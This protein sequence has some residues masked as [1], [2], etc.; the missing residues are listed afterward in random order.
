[1]IIREARIE[2]VPAITRI[3]NDAI[4]N[5]T[6]VYFYEPVSEQS[7]REWLPGKFAAGWRVLDLMF[8]QLP[9]SGDRATSR[10][11]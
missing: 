6:S 2:D 9:L 10:R 3:F 4:V 7:R 11:F 8:M 5:T 1:M